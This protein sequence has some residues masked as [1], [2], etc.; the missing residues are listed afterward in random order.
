MTA[1]FARDCAVPALAPSLRINDAKVITCS[2]SSA[3][4]W[5]VHSGL[6]NAEACAPAISGQG[7]W[8][9]QTA[10]LQNK[11]AVRPTRKKQPTRAERHSLLLELSRG[12]IL[13]F[14]P[15]VKSGTVRFSGSYYTIID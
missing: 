11:H 7:T 1:S 4:K 6:I 10:A 12:S 13:E 8:N 5:Q 9:V 14:A 3:I 15:E 2:A